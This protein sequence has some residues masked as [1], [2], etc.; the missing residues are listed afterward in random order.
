M[1]LFHNTSRYCRILFRITYRYCRILLRI[2]YRYCWILLRITY[3]YCRIL[4]RITYQ[5]YMILFREASRYCMVFFRHISLYCRIS[6]RSTPW[7]WS[8]LHDIISKHFP[9]FIGTACSYYVALLGTS[10]YLRNKSWQ[11][12]CVLSFNMGWRILVF[13]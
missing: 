12:E 1:N 4:L 10:R 6:V 3:R 5:Y 7:N 11:P 9:I 13:Y 2:I 8:V